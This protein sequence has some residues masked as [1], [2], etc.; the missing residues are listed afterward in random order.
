MK[1][2]CAQREK[3]IY[4]YIEYVLHHYT[5]YKADIAAEREAIIEASPPPPDGLPKGSGTG[6]PTESKGIN[7]EGTESVYQNGENQWGTKKS[8]AFENYINAN[9]Q[10][11]SIMKQLE[12]LIPDQASLDASEELLRFAVGK[13]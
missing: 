5:Q 13:R 11:M 6:N 3:D 10:H 8:P 12:D 7:R 2:E 4:H 1:I 9:K